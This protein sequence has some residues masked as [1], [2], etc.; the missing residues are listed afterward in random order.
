MLF[1]KHVQ[2]TSNKLNVKFF[3]I[4]KF[5]N[6]AVLKQFI[7]LFKSKQTN[8]YYILVSLII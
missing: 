3:L 6:G 2:Q 5:I 8:S 7:P 4:I 1:N